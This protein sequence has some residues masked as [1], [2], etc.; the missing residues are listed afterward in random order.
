MDRH[1]SQIRDVPVDRSSVAGK[2]PQRKSSQNFSMARPASALALTTPQIS[3]RTKR[4]IPSRGKSTSPIRS[5]RYGEL[6]RAP[7]TTFIPPVAPTDILDFP[8][9]NH[10]RIAIDKKLSSP[11]FVGGATVE[12]EVYIS[13]DNGRPSTRKKPRP[14]ISIRRIVVSLIGVEACNGRQWIFRSLAT[15]LIDEAHPPPALMLAPGHSSST[16]L[17]EVVPSSVVMPFRLDL[18]FVMGPPP[19][20]DKRAS[21]KY[22]VSTTVEAIIDD[23]T[24]FARRSQE[25]AVLTVHDRMLSTSLSWQML[26]GE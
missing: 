26:I 20:K 8:K 9:V 14:P 16:M 10:P 22:L 17:W 7:S 6:R 4:T 19:Y 1:S 2:I 23:K 12:G 24:Q 15:D 5:F 11:I 25:V 21:I 13:F 18:P 3:S